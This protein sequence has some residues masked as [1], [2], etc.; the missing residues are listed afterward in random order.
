MR[1]FFPD[2]ILAGYGDGEKPRDET[3]QTNHI[4]RTLYRVNLIAISQ[5]WLQGRPSP[6]VTYIM[7]FKNKDRMVITRSGG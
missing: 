1:R 3:L 6:M 4:C 5:D 2:D 7:V